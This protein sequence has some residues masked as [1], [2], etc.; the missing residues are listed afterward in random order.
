MPNRNSVRGFDVIEDIKTVIESAC[1]LT[2]SCADIV[3][4]AAREAVVL[5]R[6][7]L[8][9][10]VSYQIIHAICIMDVIYGNHM[11]FYTMQTGGPFWPVPLGRRD[12]L[13][14]S[15]QAA[16]TNLPS[17]FEPLENITAKFVS[18]GLD[19][20]DVVVLSGLVNYQ[21][22]IYNNKNVKSS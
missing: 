15:E 3:A 12:S 4:L 14:A 21:L 11:A 9:P 6:V 17:P 19:F 1:P 8:N 18:L 10:L 7:I 20:K 16:N 5:V 22:P 2:V 13:T